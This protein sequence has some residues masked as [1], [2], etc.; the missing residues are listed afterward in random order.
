MLCGA[1]FCNYDEKWRFYFSQLC[2]GKS[3]FIA[4]NWK[5]VLTW[6]TFHSFQ[7]EKSKRSCYILG[8]IDFFEKCEFQIA[9]GLKIYVCP[10]HI[11]PKDFKNRMGIAKNLQNENTR[12]I[13]P[14]DLALYAIN[15]RNISQY[16]WKQFIFF[17][18]Y[19]TSRWGRR[20]QEIL[21]K[22]LG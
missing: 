14:V 10:L 7:S 11:S 16:L 1:H 6:R 8:W 17:I 5:T 22:I 18:F 12:P 9:L 2:D 20:K 4:W 21:R 15:W 19:M 3:I 13:N